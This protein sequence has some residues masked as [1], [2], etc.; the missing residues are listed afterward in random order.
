MSKAVRIIGLVLAAGVASSQAKTVNMETAV[1]LADFI[2]LDRDFFTIQESDIPKIQVL[3]TAVGGKVVH[4]TSDFGRE[5]GMQP[6]ALSRGRSLFRQAGRRSRINR[7]FQ[8]DSLWQSL[9][10]F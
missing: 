9:V 10:G 8:P 4:M 3:L 1:K 5:V 2:V 7:D 6:Y